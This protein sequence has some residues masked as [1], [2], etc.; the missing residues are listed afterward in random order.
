MSAVMMLATG[1]L[2]QKKAVSLAQNKCSSQDNPDFAG[3]RE[4]IKGALENDETKNQ[5][6][7]WYVAGLIG[8]KQKDY[9]FIQQQ[10]GKSYDMEEVGKGVVESFKYWL[11]ADEIAMTP[12]LDKKGREVVDTKTRA[13]VAE[14]IAEYYT[15]QDL[16]K[17]GIILNDKRDF[18]AAYDVF[19][20][21]LSIP[22]LPMMKD[23]KY[24]KDM[25]KDSIYMQYK[26]YAAV[27]A[28]QSERHD[29]AI[30]LYEQMKD[31]DYEAITVNQFLYQEYVAL[32]DTV[33]YVRVL[34]EATAKFPNEPWFLQNLI[35]HYIYSGQTAEAITYLNQAIEREPNMVQYYTILGRI[36][37][38]AKDFDK[39]NEIYTKARNIDANSADAWAGLGY[40]LMDKASKTQDELDPRLSGKAYD[41]AL[42]EINKMYREAI[43]YFEKAHELDPENT[44]YAR[45]LKS[46]FF[47]LRDEAGMTE[48][49]EA[50]SAEIN[51][52]Y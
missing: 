22:E 26:Y 9:A 30:A 47:R 41:A 45:N 33:N 48:K 49:Y 16:V 21:H 38:D 34:Q 43:P 31:G 23:S 12:T 37:N 24:L 1:C 36:Y 50:I 18:S 8:Y 3:A 39:A 20:M 7:T 2:A 6:N 32:K 42:K 40:V 52:R 29:E 25:P 46:I 13:K 10:F 35:N 19:M 14:K 28:T 27:F 5:A 11:K 4:A 51:S 17:Y 44:F 15:K